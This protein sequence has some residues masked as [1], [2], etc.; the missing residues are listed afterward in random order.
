MR[1]NYCDELSNTEKRKYVSKEFDKLTT[2]MQ[3]LV[4]ATARERRCSRVEAELFLRYCDREY[5]KLY[6]KGLALSSFLIYG[7]DSREVRDVLAKEAA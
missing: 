6:S 2:D 7:Q 1:R 5:E 4:L 3:K